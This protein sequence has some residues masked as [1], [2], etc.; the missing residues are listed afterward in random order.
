MVASTLGTSVSATA[1]V[2]VAMNTQIAERRLFLA[3]SGPRR[4][5]GYRI[6]ELDIVRS[7]VAILGTRGGLR[8]DMV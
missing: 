4:T 2:I 6:F 5:I 7:F 3:L 1:T 8:P